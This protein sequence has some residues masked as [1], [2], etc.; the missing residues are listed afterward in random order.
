M[1]D[2]ADVIPLRQPTAAEL[3]EPFPDPTNPAVALVVSRAVELVESGAAT[4]AEAITYA[5]V[6]GYAEG[7]GD[8]EDTLA[9]YDEDGR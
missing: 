7:W 3:G 5:A 2:D 4:V 6:N 9:D 8:A 1:P